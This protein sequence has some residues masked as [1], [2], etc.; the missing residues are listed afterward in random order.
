MLLLDLTGLNRHSIHEIESIAQ[1]TTDRLHQFGF[2]VNHDDPIVNILP[3]CNLVT[4][5]LIGEGLCC[6]EAELIF[7]YYQQV[8]SVREDCEDVPFR[9]R[10]IAL[11][12]GDETVCYVKSVVRVLRRKPFLWVGQAD[13][14]ELM[15][16]GEEVDVLVGESVNLGRRGGR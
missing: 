2:V 4:L 1:C 13:L 6:D 11:L 8:H 5:Y 3:H 10:T 7:N 9:L 12:E 16:C 15:R 14:A